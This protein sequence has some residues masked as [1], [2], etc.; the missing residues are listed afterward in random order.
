[1]RHYFMK[2]ARLGFSHWEDADLP[3]ARLLWGDPA[4][5]RYIC[6]AGVFSE[7]EIAARFALERARQRDCGASY[8]PLFLQADD[9]FI[10]CCGLRPGPETAEWEL[11]VHLL[12]VCWRRGFALEATKAAVDHAFDALN[13]KAVIA[14]HHPYNP[15]SP[16]LLKRLGFVQI[17]PHFYPPTGLM[18]PSYRLIR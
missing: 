13:A 9:V 11:G 14:G 1:M 5:C 12:P 15:A 3:L 6:A 4:V 16:A 8:W 10:G 2:T 7:E 18:H 17:E